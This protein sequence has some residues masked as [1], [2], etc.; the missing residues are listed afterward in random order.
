V[1]DTNTLVS[2]IISAGGPPRRL[3][4]GVKAQQFDFYSSDIL[5]AEL[6]DVL[7]R[8][9]FAVRLA[10]AGLKAQDLVE[11]MRRLAHLVTPPSIVPR[12]VADDPDDDHVLA[13]SIAASAELIVSG[14][15]HLHSLG[16]QYQGIPIVKP[17]EAVKIIEAG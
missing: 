5:L 10:Q 2:G 14:D 8:T 12:I 11:D 15:R 7:T 17:A 16:G 9:K 4:E 1:L 6:L 3:I 13:C